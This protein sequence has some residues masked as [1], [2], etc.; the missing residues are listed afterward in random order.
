MAAVDRDAGAAVQRATAAAGVQPPSP[1]VAVS[2]D[3][4]VDESPAASVPTAADS[5]RPSTARRQKTAPAAHQVLACS[6]PQLEAQ[7]SDLTHRAAPLLTTCYVMRELLSRCLA[8]SKAAVTNYKVMT[9]STPAAYHEHALCQ[10]C[11]SAGLVR[12]R[13]VQCRTLHFA[14]QA[15]AQPLVVPDFSPQHLATLTPSVLFRCC[16]H[17]TITWMHCGR[18]ERCQV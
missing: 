16:V 14:M 18:P 11:D 13:P 17:L 8:R 15:P 6:R 7:P 3:Q 9:R 12:S 1:A 2:A 10:R 4:R 5:R